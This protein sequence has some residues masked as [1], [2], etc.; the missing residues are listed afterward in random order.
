[1]CSK[2]SVM[3]L[4]SS[5]KNL[6]GQPYRLG[7]RITNRL[8][9]FLRFVESPLQGRGHIRGDLRPFDGR[10]VQMIFKME[11]ELSCQDDGV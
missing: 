1:M 3:R 4:A 9:I 11:R 5:P 2:P 10:G 8:P 6:N 7:F